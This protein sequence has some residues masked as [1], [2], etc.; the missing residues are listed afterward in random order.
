P[1]GIYRGRPGRDRQH[2][3]RCPRWVRHRLPR[4]F[5]IGA[6]ILALVGVPGVHDPDPGPDLPTDGHPRSTLRRPGMTVKAAPSPPARPSPSP[7]DRLR[8]FAEQHR[9]ITFMVGMTIVTG[10]MTVL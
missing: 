3:W 8:D 10:L 2:H 4:E 7:R 5:R 1:Q 9:S 6:R